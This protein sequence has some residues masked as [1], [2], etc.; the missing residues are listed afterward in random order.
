LQ[1]PGKEKETIANVGTWVSKG[2]REGTEYRNLIG[3]MRN[4]EIGKY[5]RGGDYTT[6]RVSEVSQGV[7]LLTISLNIYYSY[8]IFYYTYNLVYKYTHT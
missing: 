5:K 1:K 3:E 2:K 7:M 6:G 4:R 8:H